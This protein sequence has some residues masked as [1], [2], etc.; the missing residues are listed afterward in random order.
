MIVITEWSAIR[1]SLTPTHSVFIIIKCELEEVCDMLWIIIMVIC[2]DTH[3]VMYTK[4]KVYAVTFFLLF[5]LQCRCL[6]N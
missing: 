1:M 5:C 3:T 4:S 6:V 2:C